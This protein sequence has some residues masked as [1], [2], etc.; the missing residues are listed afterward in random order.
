M[1]KRFIGNVTIVLTEVEK[2]LFDGSVCVYGD[3]LYRFDKLQLGGLAR[4]Q[5]EPER[6]DIAASQALF[7]AI[8]AAEK[9]KTAAAAEAAAS[10][11]YGGIHYRFDN[12]DGLIGGQLLGAHVATTMLQPVPEP[13]SLVLTGVG[14]VGIALLALRRPPRNRQP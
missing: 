12:D 4:L 7:F 10:R 13:T 5:A 6:H 11:L 2:G 8:A 1:K 9:R 14:A 3:V